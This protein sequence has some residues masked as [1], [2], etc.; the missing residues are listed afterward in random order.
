MTPT[1]ALFICLPVHNLSLLE[2]LKMSLQMCC[3]AMMIVHFAS[4]ISTHLKT[5]NH[6]IFSQL[7]SQFLFLSSWPEITN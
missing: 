1:Q 4:G 5:R 2:A 3:T 6:Y 7:T